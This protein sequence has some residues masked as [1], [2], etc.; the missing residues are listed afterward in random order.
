M[1]PGIEPRWRLAALLHD[2]PEYVIGDLISPFKAAVGLDYKAFE[3]KL[4]QA[5]HRRLGLPPT[6]P[7]P[8]AALIKQADRIAAYYE[9][10]VL[11][12]FGVD[13]AERFFGKPSGLPSSLQKTL[14]SLA[15][16]SAAA[17]HAAFLQ[18]FHTLVDK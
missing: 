4:L 12:G 5:I 9:A 1:Q 14:G 10:T 18:R 6:L 13:E 8:V 11:A 16:Q 2:L 3:A 7:E 17:A 15:A